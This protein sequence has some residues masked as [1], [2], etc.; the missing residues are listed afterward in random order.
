LPFHGLHR[1]CRLDHNCEPTAYALLWLRVLAGNYLARIGWRRFKPVPVFPVTRLLLSRSF[2]FRY[3]LSPS[4][5][6]RTELS[7]ALS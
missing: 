6:P 4:R 1:L 5:R 2:I 7:A 3:F